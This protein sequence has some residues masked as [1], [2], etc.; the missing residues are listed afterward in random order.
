MRGQGKC[1]PKI[2]GGEKKRKSLVPTLAR[3]E[4]E[5]EDKH[6]GKSEISR[7]NRQAD[8]QKARENKGK[9]IDTEDAETI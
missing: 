7:R 4:E 3:K 8:R 1:G 9:R 6:K 5:E 2:D